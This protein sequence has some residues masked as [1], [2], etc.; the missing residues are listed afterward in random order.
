MIIQGGMGV[1][2]SDWRLARA[3][4]KTGQLGVVSGTA[5]GVVLARRLQQGDP[6]GDVR[7]ALAAFPVPGVADR[8][9]AAHFVAG[10]LAAG[11]PYRLTAMPT[12]TPGRPLE[13]LMVAGGFVEVWL[14]KEGHGGLVGLNLLEK[15]QLP[16]LPTLYGAL[17]AGVDVV[18]MGAGIPRQIPGV[19]DRFAAG[20]AAELRIDVAGARE[21]ETYLNRFDPSAYLGRAAPALVR[22]DFLAIVAGATL[23]QT[24]AR[25]S[26]GRV[27]GFVIERDTAGGHNAPP[28]GPLTLTPEGEPA[29]G[30]RDVPDLEAFRALRLPFWLAGSYGRPGRLGEALAEGAAGVQV[31]TAFAFC[32]ESG[33][34]PVLKRETIARSRLGAV[35]VFTDPR[36][37]P[38]GFPFKVVGVPGSASEAEV[39]AGRKRVCDL[40]FLRHPYRRDDGSLG[41]RC[42]SEPVDDYVRK[43]GALADT[44]GRKCVCNGLAGVVGLAQVR[45]SGRPDAFL[46]TAGNDVADVA[47]WAAPG[48]DGYGAAEVV[49][50]RLARLAAPAV[51]AATAR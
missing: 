43:G 13:D 49:E 21:G 11:A 47:Q 16:T 17:L 37:S 10:G 39:Y 20:G 30:P 19:L 45:A 2:V 6:H 14:A 26:S 24:L 31:G 40:G 22:P 12:L 41:Y 1:A 36:A 5:I 15:I 3:V 25:K 29:Y 46:M 51:P 27:D 18:L 42:P 33:I 9:L 23:A 38:T 7:R 8:L 48:R 32:D 34:D 35:R 28:R 44:V 50:R 4:S